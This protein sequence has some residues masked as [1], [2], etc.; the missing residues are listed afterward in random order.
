MMALTGGTIL[1]FPGIDSAIQNW[2]L[3]AGAFLVLVILSYFFWIRL[4]TE[5]EGGTKWAMAALG[6]AAVGFVFLLIDMIGGRLFHPEF[7][8]VRSTV[9]NPTFIATVSSCPLGT[10]A[11]LSG[12]ARSAVL[13]RQAG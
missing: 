3:T 13:R 7:G 1:L 11:F 9:S 5:M 10:F 2:P 12:W 4:D 8:F 6:T